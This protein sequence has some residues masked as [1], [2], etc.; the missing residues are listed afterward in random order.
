M[1]KNDIEQALSIL[2][3]GET[4]KTEIEELTPLP[5]IVRIGKLW[6]GRL[7]VEI[8]IEAKDWIHAREIFDGNGLSAAW[9]ALIDFVQVYN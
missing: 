8:C 1:K 2:P 7:K 9:Q 6:K 5:E 3:V 4:L